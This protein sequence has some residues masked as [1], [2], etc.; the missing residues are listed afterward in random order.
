MADITLIN[1]NMLYLKH[2]DGIERERH[3]PLGPLY[4]ASALEQAGLEV[5]FRDYQQH[6][7]DDIFASEA[8]ADFCRDPAPI[9]G[10]SCMANLLP[11][12]ILAARVLRERYPDRLIVLGGV[13]AKSVEL[14][15]LEAFPW[16]DVVAHG[17]GERTVVEL[18]RAHRAG[19]PL[20]GIRGL[21]LR[22][23]AP[24]LYPAQP[25]HAD[26]DAIPRPAY[27][28]IDVSSYEGYGMVTSR[29]CPYLC[30]FCSVAPIWNH[31][32]FSRS[33]DGLVDEMRMLHEEAGVDLFLFQDEFFV[34]SKRHVVGFCEA[35][36][37]ARLDI[38]W[39]AFGRINLT[40]IETMDAMARTGCV[41]IRYGIE[42]GSNRVLERTKKGFSAEESVEVVS[43]AVKRFPRVDAFFVWGFPF[44]TMD[45]FYQTLFQMISFRLMGARILPSLLCYLPQTPI[46]KE[47]RGDPKFEFCPDLLPEYMLTGHEVC[48]P[49]GIAIDDE[50]GWVFDFIVQHPTIFP[51]FFHYDMEGNVRPKLEV[52]REHGFYAS[53]QDDDDAT[54]SCGAHSPRVADDP[55]RQILTRPD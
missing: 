53:E 11:F 21:A 13:G 30:T 6:E 16:I 34:S 19:E 31:Q 10:L 15:V 5:D 39:K 52:L 3:L 23:G 26:L 42:S 33:V 40:D 24:V 44:E 48:R 14:E 35:L 18:V 47:Y 46:Y 9:I 28:H 54:E 55:R 32:S 43:E 27:H 25:R 17:E 8:I 12:T 22:N 41:E 45:D 50:H 1:L 7:C 36:A 37:R 2:M 29:G 51:G 38:H 20:A 4:L 49:S